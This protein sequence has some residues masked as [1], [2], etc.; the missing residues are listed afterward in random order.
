MEQIQCNFA[1]RVLIPNGG[2]KPAATG[3]TYITSDGVKV[4]VK[5]LTTWDNTDGRYDNELDEL[6]RRLW[7]I[8]FAYIRSMW[9]SRLYYVGNYWHYVELTKI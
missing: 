2:L 3:E 4:K 5:F 7:G 1:E 9:V 6:C 8:D